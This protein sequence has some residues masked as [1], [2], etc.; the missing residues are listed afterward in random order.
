MGATNAHLG[1]V[2]QLVIVLVHRTYSC[3]GVLIAS[4]ILKFS[5]G[6]LVFYFFLNVMHRHINSHTLSSKILLV[7][8]INERG[9]LSVPVPQLF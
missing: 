1:L 2:C 4:P 3:V 5:L 9:K 8:K 7:G 6:L